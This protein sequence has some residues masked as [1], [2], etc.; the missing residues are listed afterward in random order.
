MPCIFS[1][2]LHVLCRVSVWSCM[3]KSEIYVIFVYSGKFLYP[4]LM[5]KYVI[6]FSWLCPWLV[7]KLS[8][9]HH[10]WFTSYLSN[11]SQFVSYNGVNSDLKIFNMVYH[12]LLYWVHLSFF[13][14]SL[15]W[16]LRV[17][18]HSQFCLVTISISFI[19]DENPDHVQQ[20]INDELK[21]I[22]IWLRANKLSLNINKARYILFSY[23]N[24][25]QPNIT[26]EINEQPIICITKTKFP[27]VIID[28]KLRAHFICL[29]QSCQ[30]HR[31]DFQS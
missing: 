15:T 8:V 19:S 31:C 12:K 17:K 11:R 24:V 3:S 10:G 21:Y 27:G 7:R 22:V 6:L 4:D 30:R 25:A 16:L 13:Y 20:I 9:K 1:S 18:G 28:N 23:K 14:I 2:L 26:I 5:G 29:W